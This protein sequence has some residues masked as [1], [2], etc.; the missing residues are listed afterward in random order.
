VLRNVLP[1]VRK[2]ADAG[3]VEFGVSRPRCG[4]RRSTT[5]P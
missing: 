1:V 2:V 4:D 3:R 5:R